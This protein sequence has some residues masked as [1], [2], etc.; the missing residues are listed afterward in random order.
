MKYKFDTTIDT[1]EQELKELKEYLSVMS[2][3]M[4]D[5]EADEFNPK[6]FELLDQ[7]SAIAIQNGLS[8]Q[9]TRTYYKIRLYME[10]V[11]NSKFE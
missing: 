1:I 10:M 3:T 4:T 6:F 9:E 11:E 2:N 5:E 7:A 8:P